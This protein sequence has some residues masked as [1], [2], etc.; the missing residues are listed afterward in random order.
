MSGS[1]VQVRQ[2][3]VSRFQPSSGTDFVSHMTTVSQADRWQSEVEQ[4]SNSAKKQTR[5]KK[6]LRSAPTVDEAQLNG[7]I[8]YEPLSELNLYENS[9][10]QPNETNHQDQ[11]NKLRERLFRLLSKV[12]IQVETV[13]PSA[14][15]ESKNKII[16][17]ISCS[18]SSC[19]S[20]S[21]PRCQQKKITD[22]KPLLIKYYNE[23]S[24]SEILSL[25]FG[26]SL[27][28]R[29][30][31]PELEGAH[32]ETNPIGQANEYSGIKPIKSIGVPAD[33]HRD[34][35]EANPLGEAGTM[36]QASHIQPSIG[37]Y[38]DWPSTE[39]GYNQP[40][41]PDQVYPAYETMISGKGE[42]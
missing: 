23:R 33:F 25:H 40:S 39:P 13:E 4:E 10:S 36:I 11:F 7:A 17:G 18:S 1:N 30:S 12:P 28:S 41:K 6:N 31:R 5:V 21:S 19:S 29:N 8:G 37:C 34:P 2:T 26:C 14:P 38:F 16:S 42:L 32:F 27:M 20:I 3:E 15:I 35:Q 22:R 24:L 9:S